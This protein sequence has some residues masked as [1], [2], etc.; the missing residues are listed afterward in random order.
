MPLIKLLNNLRDQFPFL[1]NCLSEE[2]GLKLPSQKGHTKGDCEDHH[3][4]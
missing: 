2:F 4:L 1:I 3:L